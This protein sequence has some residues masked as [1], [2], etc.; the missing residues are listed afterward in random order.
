MKYV[1]VDIIMMDT[2]NTGPYPGYIYTLCTY[3]HREFMGTCH[4]PTSTLHELFTPHDLTLLWWLDTYVV[5]NSLF[6]HKQSL[7][8]IS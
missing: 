5:E 7:P 3:V 1:H 4:I 6:R 2:G 8:G